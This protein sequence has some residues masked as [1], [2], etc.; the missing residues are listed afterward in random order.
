MNTLNLKS[1]GFIYAL[2][3]FLILLLAHI[4]VLFGSDPLLDISFLVGFFIIFPL[5][6]LTIFF[7]RKLIEAN[8]EDIT[9]LSFLPRMRVLLGNPPQWLFIVV[10]IFYIYGIYCFYLWMTGGMTEPELVNG[11][12]QFNN[13][14]EITYYTENEY[15]QAHKKNILA[16]TGVL[17]TFA[18]VSLSIFLPIKRDT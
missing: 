15:I 2:I 3:A 11:Q 13:H 17:L 14:G 8:D 4:P 5:W 16:S 12:Y 6:G 9:K 1:I 18:S 7:M 10:G